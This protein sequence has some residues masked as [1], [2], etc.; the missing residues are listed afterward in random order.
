MSPE[1]CFD[2]I[3]CNNLE[4]GK[5]PN[6]TICSS[7]Y[8]I[9]PMSPSSWDAKNRTICQTTA[10]GRRFE[11]AL[12][13]CQILSPARNNF[14]Y[15]DSKIGSECGMDSINKSVGSWGKSCLKVPV[16]DM[17]TGSRV[18]YNFVGKQSIK[19]MGMA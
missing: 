6:Q 14:A 9:C 10:S 7:L 1:F 12:V 19:C 3:R 16:T 18:D 11:V 2:S 15:N 13:S 17:T 5:L 4:A 8:L